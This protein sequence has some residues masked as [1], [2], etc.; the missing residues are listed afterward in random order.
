LNVEFDWLGRQ[1]YAPIFAQ[2]VGRAAAIAVGEASEAI[3]SCEHEPVYTTGRRAVDNRVTTELPA[4]LLQS[5]RGGETT[6]HGPGQ[7]MLYPLI[8]LRR[9]GIGV[10]DYVRLLEQ[11]CIDLLAGYEI[12]A[13]RNCGFPGVWV[14]GGK[15]A[16]LGVR[17]SQGVAYHGMALNV[18][19]DLRAFAA[20]RPCGL[21]AAVVSMESLSGIKPPLPELA[22]HWA[23]LF[24]QGLALL[25]SAGDSCATG[26][27]DE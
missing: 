19:V 13:G 1:P 6:F 12:A 9:R 7:L 4:P 26:D 17:V 22:R 23:Q 10:R 5:D 20:I 3:W 14:D 18:S 27:T 25:D 21:D 2:L 11:S 15:I 16:A 24:V 8:D